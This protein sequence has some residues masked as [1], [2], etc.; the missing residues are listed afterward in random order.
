ML[1]AGNELTRVIELTATIWMSTR[2]LLETRLRPLSMTWPQFGALLALTQADG[3][4]QRGLGEVLECDRTTISVICDSLEKHGWAERRA[5][6]VDRRA[7]RLFLT[8]AGREVTREA[9]RIVWGVYESIADV[10][11]AEEA[12]SIALKLE[13]VDEALKKVP[14]GPGTAAPE[15]DDKVG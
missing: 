15:L 11:S 1:F 8:D 2:T 3:V 7:K 13:L 14:K 5:D 10:L 6:M 4:T 9:E 12:A